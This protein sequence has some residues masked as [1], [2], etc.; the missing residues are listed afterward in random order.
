LGLSGISNDMREL[1][2]SADARA[3]FA[4]DYFV[5]AVTKQLGALAATLGGLDAIVFT[6]GIGERSAIIRAR[7]CQA[8]AWLGVEL[9]E[10]ANARHGPRISRPRSR[11]AAWVRPTK[12]ELMI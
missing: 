9:D 5:C 1:L 8:A 2:A 4:V 10:D 3:A 12:Q 7:V 6:A 11:A